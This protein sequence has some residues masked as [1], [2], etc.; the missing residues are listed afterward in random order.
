M[1]Q[2]GASGSPVFYP[3]TAKVAGIL[4][5]GLNDIGQTRNKDIYRLPTNI[6]YVVPS[7]YLNLFLKNID[8]DPMLAN[9]KDFPTLEEVLKN[10]EFVNR[11][12]GTMKNKIIEVKTL[13]RTSGN[14]KPFNLDKD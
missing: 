10:A 6:S 11:F 7:H 3:D 8:K 4:Y 12:E 14:L 13:Q 5:A 2:G 1:T 9:S